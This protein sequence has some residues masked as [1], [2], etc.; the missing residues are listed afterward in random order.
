[1]YGEEGGEGNVFERRCRWA[2][3]ER[4]VERAMYGK[5]RGGGQGM[6]AQGGGGHDGGEEKYVHILYFLIYI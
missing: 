5:G 6:Y 4:K 2:C 3:V 1:M